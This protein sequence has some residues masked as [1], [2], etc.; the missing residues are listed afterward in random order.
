M[1]FAPFHGTARTV[2]RPGTTSQRGRYLGPECY[3]MLEAR[4]RL[5]EPLELGRTLGKKPHRCWHRAGLSEVCT[6]LAK[7]C[8]GSGLAARDRVKT[9]TVGTRLGNGLKTVPRP[10]RTLQYTKNTYS[11][12][13][14]GRLKSPPREIQTLR[15]P[16]QNGSKLFE[17]VRRGC[18]TAATIKMC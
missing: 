7:T 4:A 15:N 8:P 3:I 16:F 13:F 14:R 9:P 5:G 11:G 12:R 17:S 18:K 6:G 2:S 10:L 1:R